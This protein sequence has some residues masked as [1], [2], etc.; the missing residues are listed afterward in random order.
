LTTVIIM[1][2]VLLLMVVTAAALS[3]R[4]RFNALDYENKK[5]SVGLAEACANVAMLELAKNPAQPFASYPATITIDSAA[6]TFCEVSCISPGSLNQPR[7]IVTRAAYRG[8]YVNRASYT[9]LA[10]N[11]T[12]IGSNFNIDSWN[13]TETFVTCV[14]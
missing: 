7:K 2:A 12:P 11:V 4:G 13:E 8:Q 5:I 10:V 14:P 6:G 9:N 1:S 3:F